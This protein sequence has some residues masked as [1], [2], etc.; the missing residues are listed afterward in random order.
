LGCVITHKV[1]IASSLHPEALDEDCAR[2]KVVVSTAQAV[3]CKG[4]AVVIDQRAAEE[5][6]G[7][8]VTLSPAPTTISVRDYRGERPWVVMQQR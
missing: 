8:R 2:A 1:L 4:P 6:E 5:G 3:N 7:W